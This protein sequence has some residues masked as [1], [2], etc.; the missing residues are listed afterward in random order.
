MEDVSGRAFFWRCAVKHIMCVRLKQ[1]PIDRI[2]RRQPRRRRDDCG[3]G[4]PPASFETAGGTPAPQSCHMRSSWHDPLV[5]VRTVA[6]R[7][8]VVAA[9]EIAQSRGITLGMTLAEA[10]ALC[11]RLIHAD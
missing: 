3:A 4:V 6:S 8:V 10:R 11:A 5:L 9:C 2:R 1:W 7:Q